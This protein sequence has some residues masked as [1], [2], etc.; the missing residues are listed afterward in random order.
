[1]EPDNEQQTVQEL[2]TTNRDLAKRIEA[3]EKVSYPYINALGLI[4]E[5]LTQRIEAL[6]GTGN[7]A[8]LNR[9]VEILRDGEYM[10]FDAIVQTLIDSAITDT[11][12]VLE[13]FAGKQVF[14]CDSA[15]TKWRLVG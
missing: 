4:S 13:E 1:M 9:V 15:G 7:V 8:L 11:Y 2:Q 3:L 14:E 10:D 12:A 6:E 5:N